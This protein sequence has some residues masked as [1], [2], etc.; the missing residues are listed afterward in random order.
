MAHIPMQD[1]KE[2]YNESNH[3]W[4]GL[5][6]T[7]ES[8]KGKKDGIGDYLIIDLAHALKDMHG[9]SYP[10]SADKLYEILNQK[11]EGMPHQ[12]SAAREQFEGSKNSR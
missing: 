10:D 4:D 6:K 11:L 9:Q 3:S 12:T 5:E 8:H 1:V 7:V 2:L